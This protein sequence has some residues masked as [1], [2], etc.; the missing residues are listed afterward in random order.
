MT[1]KLSTS[2]RRRKQVAKP[3]RP[4]KDFPLFPHD[5]GQWAKKVRG[6]LFYFGTWD[7]PDAAER[8]WDIQK[9]AILEGR[10]PSEVTSSGDSLSWLINTFMDA[11]QLQRNRGELTQRALNDYHRVCKHVAK[12]FGKD[13]R[14][15]TIRANEFDEYKSSFPDTWGP[16]TVNN[17]LRLARVLFKFA[18]D[19]EATERPIRYSIGL[20]AVSRTIARKHAATKPAKEFTLLEVHRLLA[21]SNVTMQAFIYLGLNC[22]Y[23]TADIARLQ[24]S[25]IDWDQQWLGKIRGKTGM[26]RGAW[27]WPETLEALRAAIEASPEAKHDEHAELAFLTRTRRPWAEDGGKANNTLSQAFIKVKESAGID[28]PGVGHYAL[29]HVFETIAGDA[30]DQPATDFVMGHVDQSMAGNYREGIDPSRIRAVC[31]YVRR[32]FLNMGPTTLV[33]TL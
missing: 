2:G 8:K 4:R 28:K 9:H 10:N 19:I 23:G 13:R 18:N 27:L 6:K 25:D 33:E 1:V 24:R 3:A 32:R 14:L 22:G 5:S 20:K 30:K 15:E 16:V 11:K 26:A 7:D 29:R 21:V 31:E 12:Y 17:H